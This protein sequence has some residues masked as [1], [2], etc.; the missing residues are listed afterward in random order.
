M[1]LND[2]ECSIFAA[3]AMAQ[4][5]LRLWTDM[6]P[7]RLCVRDG[8]SRGRGKSGEHLCLFPTFDDNYRN[9]CLGRR[10]RV[11]GL[12]KDQPRKVA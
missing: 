5:I 4:G 12:I 7:G 11:E 8:L 1:R 6:T 10:D 9:V 3:V 2:G